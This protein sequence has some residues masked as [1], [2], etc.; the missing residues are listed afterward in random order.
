[1]LGNDWSDEF[2]FD[3]IKELYALIPKTQVFHR[4]KF[5]HA[6]QRYVRKCGGNCY[7]PGATAWI[8]S[9]FPKKQTKGV[10]A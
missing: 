9:G 7:Y 6:V 4:I 10:G 1:M 8:K 2:G 3:L 5:R